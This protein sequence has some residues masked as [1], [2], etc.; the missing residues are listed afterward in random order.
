VKDL[1]KPDFIITVVWAIGAMTVL[2][3][4]GMEVIHNQAVVD[5]MLLTIPAVSAIIM[6]YWFSKKSGPEEPPK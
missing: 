4:M 2:V 1:L 6:G 5:K 3:L